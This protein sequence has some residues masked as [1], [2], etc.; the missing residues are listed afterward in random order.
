MKGTCPHPWSWFR[1]W[2]EFPGAV[3]S[4]AYGFNLF[5]QVFA[6]QRPDRV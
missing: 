4:V 3:Q 6:F 5:N 1:G 2:L